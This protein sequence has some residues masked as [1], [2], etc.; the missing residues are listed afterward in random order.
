M[1]LQAAGLIKIF[2]D[3]MQEDPY[4][5]EG[6]KVGLIQ[7]AVVRGYEKA[8]RMVKENKICGETTE[9]CVLHDTHEWSLAAVPEAGGPKGSRMEGAHEFYYTWTLYMSR[10]RDLTFLHCHK[11]NNCHGPI[12]RKCYEL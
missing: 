6:V 12:G 10:R 2:D 11:S 3:T 5:R 9:L 1:F 4:K 7:C 8:E